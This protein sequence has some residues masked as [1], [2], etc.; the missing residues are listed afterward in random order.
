MVPPSESQPQGNL[1]FGE[2][3]IPS[4]SQFYQ[5]DQNY[6]LPNGQGLSHDSFAPGTGEWPLGNEIFPVG[7]GEIPI[8]IPNPELGITQ[9]DTMFLGAWQQGWAHNSSNG[10]QASDGDWDLF[11]SQ[12]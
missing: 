12:P 6:S 4:N 9:D 10:T 5:Q 1:T 3:A 8:S 2:T 7:V 11:F